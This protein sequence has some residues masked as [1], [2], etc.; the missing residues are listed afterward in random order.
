ML[1]GGGVWNPWVEQRAAPRDC[2]LDRPRRTLNWRTKKC[3]TATTA[4]P[5]RRCIPLLR[6]LSLSASVSWSRQYSIIRSA[7]SWIHCCRFQHNS[8]VNTKWKWLR[9]KQP[10]NM[11]NPWYSFGFTYKGNCIERF[12]LFNISLYF[13]CRIW[14][15]DSWYMSVSIEG[16]EQDQNVGV[17]RLCCG[18]YLGWSS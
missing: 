15:K 7:I 5:A 17:Q 4:C 14:S 3:T 2:A 1:P 12:N 6:R 8:P 13:S 11:L 16:G 10:S 9:L 18:W